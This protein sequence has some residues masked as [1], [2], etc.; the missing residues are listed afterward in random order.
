[1]PAF[2]TFLWLT[3]ALAGCAANPPRHTPPVAALA[4]APT[5]SAS[6]QLADALELISK[7]Q[8]DEGLPALTAVIDARSFATL[9]SDEQY[10]A[11][12]EAG[13][14]EVG[15]QRWAV[16]RRYAARAA[17]MPQATG[18]DQLR[19]I[20]VTW[21]LHDEAAVAEALTMLAKRW[22]D[23]LG[24]IDEDYLAS[25]LRTANR[26][27]RGTGLALL[28]ALYD[29]HWKPKGG[30]EPSDSWRDLVLL[31]IEERKAAEAGDVAARITDPQV[32]VD[33]RADR[34]FDSV[35]AAHPGRFDVN[36]AAV[37]E[38]ESLQ[39]KDAEAKSLRVKTLL[40]AA[41][42]RRQHAAAA[43]AIADEAVA[44]I[45]ETN[46]P[47]RLYV[48]YL[49]E[50]AAL[51]SERAFALM[52]LG[53]WN[54]AADQLTAATREFEHG[55]DNVGAAIDLAAFECDLGRPKE[56]RSVLAQL[57]GTL[58]PYGSMQ[59]ESVRLD[60]ATQEGDAAQ[61]ERSLHYLHA[62]RSDAPFAYLSALVVA[63]QLNRA[64]QEL[65]GQ[66]AGRDTRQQALES[67]QTYLSEPGTLRQLEM[68][69]RWQSVIARLD[70]QA[71]IA[72]VG[73]VDSYDLVNS[74]F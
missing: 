35:V 9:S 48:D 15:F 12:E 3:L 51:L 72:R 24:E 55:H 26:L 5:P 32:L 22:P 57:T 69:A 65:R 10:R 70:V 19:L 63:D 34:R 46:Y 60:A 2:R 49:S 37:R 59:M 53:H 71:A 38:I 41:L 13:Q 17:A 25:V 47:E 30:V 14:I 28:Q 74:I 64:A 73:R 44:A 61:I 56:A 29:A 1:M 40:M 67:A 7:K 42:M 33:M 18:N 23:R 62:H 66:L 11:L 31:L 36:A 43:L 8:F 58:S 27:P 52:D 20:A 6:R 4:G 39:A 21:H 50:Y 45:L 68:R 16:A 54:E